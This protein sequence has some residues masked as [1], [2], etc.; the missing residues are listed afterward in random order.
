MRIKARE[1]V[2]III[3]VVAVSSAVYNWYRPP[4]EIVRDHYETVP[5][6]KVVEKIKRVAVPGP[7]EIITIEKEPLAKELGIPWL[8]DQGNENQQPIANAD[9]PPSEGGTSVVTIMDTATG[10][11]KII[12]KGKPLSLFDFENKLEWE[13]NYALS[14]KTSQNANLGFRWGFL[15]I[16]AIHPHLKAEVNSSPEAKILIGAHGN[17]W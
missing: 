7:K 1:I 4:K 3:A 17:L 15:R 11:S 9:I 2:L 16:M 14:T 12:A 10:E 8:M 6:E 5:V 13:I